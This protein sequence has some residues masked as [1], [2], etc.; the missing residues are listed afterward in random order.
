M[1]NMIR[2]LEIKEFSGLLYK[3]RKVKSAEIKY[4]SYPRG[5]YAME[6]LMG[7]EVYRLKKRTKIVSL[8]IDNKI[9]MVNDPLHYYGMQ[10]LAKACSGKVLVAG[11]GLGIVVRFLQQNE[12]VSKIDVYEINKDVIKLIKLH[13]F[14]NKKVN[15]VNEN[16]FETEP[17]RNDYDYTIMDLWIKNDDEKLTTRVC[18]QNYEVNMITYYYRVQFNT[19]SR[20]FVWGV[21]DP[22]MNPG[23]VMLPFKSKSINTVW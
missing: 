20:V 22:V 2:V 1:N 16:F 8:M 19:S 13:L 18:G 11:L 21:K 3:E 14:R 15:I 7:Y 23:I 10:K 5:M 17:Y 4:I 6:N 9:V 12:K